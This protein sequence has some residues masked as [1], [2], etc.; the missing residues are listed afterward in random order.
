LVAPDVTTIRK[1]TALIEVTKDERQCGTNPASDGVT[2]YVAGVL[3]RTGLV[4]ARKWET[5]G[6]VGKLRFRSISWNTHA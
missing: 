3:F 4:V 6:V 1:Y 2:V 5:M